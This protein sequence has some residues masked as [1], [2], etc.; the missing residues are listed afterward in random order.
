MKIVNYEERFGKV[1]LP[2][3]FAA[4]LQGLTVEEQTEYYRTTCYSVYSTSDWK[5]RKY[6][7][8][9]IRLEKDRDV[10]GLIVKDGLLVGIMILNDNRSEVPCLAEEKVCTYYARDN[11]GAGY[12]E[13]I[14][15]TYLICVPKAF[16]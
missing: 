1:C 8:S 11:N 2:E 4:L 12:K 15:Y 13:R 9:A 10:T 5:E 3:G 7:G 16:E 6:Q 14:D